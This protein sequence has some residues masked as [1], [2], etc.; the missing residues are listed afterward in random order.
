MIGDMNDLEMEALRIRRELVEAEDLLSP[1]GLV[2]IVCP[3]RALLAAS[4]T[5]AEMELEE[6]RRDAA[7]L[8]S[9]E[10]WEQRAA[11]RQATRYVSIDELASSSAG[12]RTSRRTTP[13][14]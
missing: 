3:S 4:I 7:K 6:S 8:G 11:A 13:Y 10:A 12:R 2:A 5:A 1:E 14:R 9:R